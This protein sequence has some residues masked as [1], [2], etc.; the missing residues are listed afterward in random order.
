MARL[1]GRR[2]IRNET[3]PNNAEANPEEEVI[4]MIVRNTNPKVTVR[5][6]DLNIETERERE[7]KKPIKSAMKR[8]APT[9]PIPSAPYL[10]NEYTGASTGTYGGGG[11]ARPKVKGYLKTSIPVYLM[12][13]DISIDQ[14][15]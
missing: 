5:K 14:N 13:S 1:F 9:P 8:T 2:Q 10:Y 6:T 11:G 3:V 12:Q 15:F 4:P 7:L